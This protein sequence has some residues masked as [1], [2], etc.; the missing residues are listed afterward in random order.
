MF[1][2]EPPLTLVGLAQ[3]RQFQALSLHSRSFFI[4]TL[5]TY[6]RRLGASPGVLLKALPRER[7]LFYISPRISCHSFAFPCPVRSPTPLLTLKRH[8]LAPRIFPKRRAIRVGPSPQARTLWRLCAY[9]GR[10]AVLSSSCRT[11]P[12]R[13]PPKYKGISGKYSPLHQYS[14][15]GAGS[16]TIILPTQRSRKRLRVGA[17]TFFLRLD[18]SSISPASSQ[19]VQKSWEN[20]YR[21]WI[22]D[23]FSAESVGDHALI[24]Y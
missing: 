22:V 17:T 11:Q 16:R 14:S 12:P 2:A 9:P 19:I 8:H 7:I 20:P 1:T 4:H 13:R 23:G 3:N 18:R 21:V 10:S 15:V 5:C 6:S 24:K